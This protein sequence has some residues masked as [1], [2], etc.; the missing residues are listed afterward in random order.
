MNHLS[1]GLWNLCYILW[2]LYLKKNAPN[3]IKR[4]LRIIRICE[5]ELT[6]DDKDYTSM[7][8][9]ERY[10]KVLDRA[11]ERLSINRGETTGF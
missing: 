11:K 1:K 2:C 8:N 9:K 10:K 7:R 3:N 6:Y 5:T 4:D